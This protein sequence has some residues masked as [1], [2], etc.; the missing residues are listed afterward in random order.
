MTTEDGKFYTHAGVTVPEIRR[1]IELNLQKGE[2]SHGAST[3]TMQLA[4]N[5]F[6]DRQRTLS[7]KL[8]ELFFVWYLEKEFTKE[9]ILELYLNVVEFGPSIYGVTDAAWHFFRREPY[10][11][12]LLESVYLVKQMPSPVDRYK[13]YVRGKLLSSERKMLD[14]VIDRMCEREKI[15]PAERDLAKE[16]SLVFY[17]EG[18]PLPEVRLPIARGIS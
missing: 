9:E 5:L 3:I 6:L 7:R 14:R 4:K 18:D 2:F 16:T 8:Q 13:S 11:L 17:R 15:T 12:S 1:A 10:E